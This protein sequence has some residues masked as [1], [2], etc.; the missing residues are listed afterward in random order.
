MV[1][2]L[3]LSNLSEAGLKK[4]G[5]KAIEHQQQELQWCLIEVNGRKKLRC[6]R[7]NMADMSCYKSSSFSLCGKVT[8]IYY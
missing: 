5:E 4:T 2:E 1:G 3:Y 6:N 7:I 8:D